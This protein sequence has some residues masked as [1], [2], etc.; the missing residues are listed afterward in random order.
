MF[1]AILAAAVGIAIALSVNFYV[2]P[3]YSQYV[4]VAILAGLDSVFGGINA[5]FQKNFKLAIFVS[6]FFGNAILAVALAYI[7]NK[8]DADLYL[9]AV[10]IFGT[11]IF[12]NFAAIRRFLL[13]QYSK[14]DKM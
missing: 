4:A 2:P 13:S 10:I 12:Q 9:A 14:K 8:L 6:G 3:E 7:G 11:R 1:L 5:N